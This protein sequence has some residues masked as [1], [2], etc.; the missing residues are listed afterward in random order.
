MHSRDFAGKLPR[1]ELERGMSESE[2]ANTRTRRPAI[3]WT[4]FALT[5]LA[6]VCLFAGCAGDQPVTTE[7]LAAARQ[8]WVDATIQDYDLE[9]TASGRMTAHYY[10]TVRQQEVRSVESMASDG[11]K[12]PLHPPDTRFYG[13][14]GLF[15]TIADELA[16]L[17]L[18]RPFDQPKGTKI[19]M[20]FSP[21]PR[22]GYPRT[23]RRNVLG[24]SQELAIDVIRLI[25]GGSR[26]A[27]PPARSP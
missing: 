17:K 10:V 25:P 7:A 3:G 9:W 24:T 2:N 13:V 27:S 4:L 1:Q 5:G 23:Y 12:T 11:R 26:P 18:D 8:A 21:D 6:A 20:R 22:L 19:V 16:Q 15:R 14:D